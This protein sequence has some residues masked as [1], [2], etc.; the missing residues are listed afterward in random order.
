[1]LDTRR[2]ASSAFD[3]DTAA[4]GGA[5]KF[6]QPMAIEFLLARGAHGDAAAGDGP[7]TPRRD[8]RGG[9]YDQLGGGFARYATDAALAGAALRED[10]LRQRAAARGPS[11]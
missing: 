7:R 5:P 4:S 8:G 10:A 6:P 2:A 9:I 3:A 11:S 1:M